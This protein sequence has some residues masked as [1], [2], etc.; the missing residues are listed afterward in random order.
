MR[1]IK[2]ARTGVDRSAQARIEDDAWS[3]VADDAEVPAQ[4]DVIVGLARYRELR[5]TFAKRA[6][7]VGVRVHSNQE[8]KELADL[9]AEL[10]L[11]AIEFPNFKDGRGYTTARLLRERFAFKGELRAIGD[12]M[13]DQL[14][15]MTRCGFDAFELKSTKSLDEALGAFSEYSVT[16]Q[17]AADDPRPLF[18]RRAQAVR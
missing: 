2:N 4:G 6:G 1:I 18:R 3:H 8:A 16:Y 9:T 11:I 14:F 10:P 5:A 15:Y 17:G 7:K 12:V 13:R